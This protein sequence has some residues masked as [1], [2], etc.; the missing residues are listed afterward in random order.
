ME[1]PIG[2]VSLSL[3]IIIGGGLTLAWSI[4]LAVVISRRLRRRRL[5]NQPLRPEFVGILERNVPLYR[6]MPAPLQAQLRGYV[7]VFLHD[8]EFLGCAGL[9]VTD[10]MRVTV[11]GNAC[12][13][14]LNRKEDYFR[15]FSNILMYPDTYVATE[16]HWDGT[17]VA[18]RDSAR[19]GESWQGGP[20]VLSWND[21]CKGAEYADDGHNV[22]LHEFAHKLDEENG[23]VDGLPVLRERGDYAEW[24]RV[25][26]KEFD[27]LARRT[28]QHNNEVMDS[29]GAS[30]PPEFF[31]VATESFFERGAL[32]KQR[33]PELYEQLQKFYGVNPAAWE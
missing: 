19:A 24:A 8:K 25:L 33:L 13:L 7:N 5:Q 15:G 31:A 26:H 23:V 2:P 17:V 11:A 14:L 28:R 1:A 21:V 20:I 18:H 9:K 29:Y 27:G 12:L 3:L 6:K 4:Y 10:E 22:V 30:S 16:A 32:M